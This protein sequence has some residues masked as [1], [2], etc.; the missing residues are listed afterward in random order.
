MK[1]KI[2]VTLLAFCLIASLCVVGAAASNAPAASEP[3]AGG[4]VFFA[5]GTSITI[6]EEKPESAELVKFDLEGEASGNDAY[7]SW[8]ND[9]G[10]RFYASVGEGIFVFGG[11]DGHI[12]PVTVPSTSI[13]M[14]GGKIYNL[15]G[16]NYGA[17]DNTAKTMSR[18][19]GDVEISIS[20]G[21]IVDNL[22][23]GGG[24]WNTCVE[25]NVYLDFKGV[26]L[27]ADKT[28]KL[29]VNGGVYGTGAEGTRD[30]DNGKMVTYA[31]AN[32]VVITAENSKFYLLGAGGSGSTKVGSGSVV[33]TDCEVDTLF[34]SG[35][36]GEVETS[37]ITMT[38]CK[39]ED[40]AATN[41]GF[42]GVGSVEINNSTVV[43]LNTGASE[44]CFQSD[45][46]S[47]DG[48]GVTG[49]V[50]YDIDANSTI[51]NAVLT[52]TV[53]SDS[54]SYEASFIN[55]SISKDGEPLNLS[56]DEFSPKNSDTVK[57]FTVPEGSTLTLS[58]VNA[59]IAEGQSVTNAGTIDVATSTLTVPDGATLA[60]AGDI[61]GKVTGS[62]TEYAVRVGSKGYD[63]LS[64]AM[65][66]LQDG[67]T[68][69]LL[70]DVKVDGTGKQNNEG[71]VTINKKN[72]TLDGNGKELSVSGTLLDADGRGP[73]A[74]N[75]Q[76][77]A[78]VT[79][80]DIT[81]NADGAKHGLNIYDASKVT[82]ED[83][84]ITNAAWY[85]V[86]CNSSELEVN[87][88]HTHGNQW[89]IN[90]DTAASSASKVVINDATIEENDSIVFE[91]GKDS[92]TE[93]TIN[94]GSFKTIKEQGDNTESIAVTVTD[95]TFAESVTDIATTPD[96]ELNSNGSFT[97]YDT[98]SAAQA[99]AK[100][101]DTITFVGGDSTVETHTV[102][103]IYDGSTTYT[104]ELADGTSFPLPVLEK[105][106]Y[107]FTGWR[108][109][110]S[111]TIVRGGESY[112]ITANTTF[113]AVWNMIMIPDTY[114]IAV[115]QPAHGTVD[116]SF[117]NASQGSVITVTA[118]PDEGYELV[119]I[120]VDGEPIS[121][122]SFVM[123]DHAV[124]VSALFAEIGKEVNF[125][126]V[127]RADWFYDYVQY[128]AQNGLMEGTTR[129]A[130]EPNASMTRAMFWTVLARI[131]GETITGDAW[132]TLA[133][134]WAVESG[135][136]DGT[137]ADALITRE[138]MVTMLYRFANSPE[139]AATGFGQFTDGASVSDYA[140]DAVTW[141]LSEGILTGMGDGILAPQGTATRAQAAAMLMRF[142]EA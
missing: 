44:G 4:N 103:V 88:L 108:V 28:N 89:G 90:V 57:D 91:N 87:G 123:P 21:A 110:S 26:D 40:F 119:Y 117:S 118:T 76:G 1:R 67:D 98:L 112:P 125:V 2:L 27:S 60:N 74:I 19:T 22:L 140:T 37:S 106:G 48:S 99:A 113:T 9:D 134:T 58:N 33:L 130:F 78:T 141:A 97:Y 71:V 121:G 18:V 116:V 72:I 64:S 30:I 12:T 142:V 54:D 13:T 25:G 17:K 14:T 49:S 32:N 86:V 124:E 34:L 24:Y 6:T 39:I 132:K 122:N 114:D 100:P 62:V 92:T 102:T 77:N 93:T 94:G 82:L 111:N 129:T 8:Y 66:V 55:V 15:F 81:I 126:D 23:H 128:V 115:D 43:N 65:A 47:K 84:E 20:G 135:I 138:Q 29:Y 63:D 11:A 95:G 52:P 85:A 53:K 50:T 69:T 139:V 56:V 31:V 41:R 7:I 107:T 83:V 131:D 133:Q 45:S 35:I 79:V 10:E 5:N 42:V 101:G 3:T 96:Y 120:T 46:G 137:N 61:I 59:E 104:Y 68:I 38:G 36:N 105:S 80:K 136:S 70:K 16:G 109:N 73:S 75:I 127:S 51:T